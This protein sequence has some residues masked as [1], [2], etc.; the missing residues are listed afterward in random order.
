M[1][2]RHGGTEGKKNFMVERYSKEYKIAQLESSLP[3]QYNHIWTEAER[4]RALYV[5]VR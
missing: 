4:D 3:K 5:I 2:S 1:K